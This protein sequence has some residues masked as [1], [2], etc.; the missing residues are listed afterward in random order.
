MQAK[1]GY[2]A[3]SVGRSTPVQGYHPYCLSPHWLVHFIILPTPL[4][5]P[6]SSIATH[7]FFPKPCITKTGALE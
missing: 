1:E 5:P 6:L 3:Y 2:D 7:S 4:G